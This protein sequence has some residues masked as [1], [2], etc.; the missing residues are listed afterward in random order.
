MHLTDPTKA[1]REM[2]RV[3]RQGGAVAAFE[4]GRFQA[5]YVP[6]DE[7]LSK[8]ANKLGLAYIDGIR[9]REGKN[10]DIEGMLPD[11]FHQAGLR[12]VAAEIQADT[13]LLRTLEE[14]WKM[15][16]TS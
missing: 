14:S 2:S 5:F 16:G 4:P 3:T 13:Y 1:V 11:F 9:K 8:L 7:R 10:F 12:D 6:D 15:F